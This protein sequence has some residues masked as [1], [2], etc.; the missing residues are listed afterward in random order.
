[1][2]IKRPTR[3]SVVELTL[4]VDESPD[5]GGEA[6]GLVRALGSHNTNPN[7][8]VEGPTVVLASVHGKFRRDGYARRA[9]VEPPA[10]AAGKS[11][12]H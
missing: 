11:E 2:P 9:P 10:T 7:P 12:A 8:L 1:M 6:E 4:L 5:L 3:R